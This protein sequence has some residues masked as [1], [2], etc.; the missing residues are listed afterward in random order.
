MRF[1]QTLTFQNE[2]KSVSL[3]SVLLRGADEVN[4]S[5]SG[6]VDFQR[7]FEAKE[8]P[9]SFH[10][11]ESSAYLVIALIDYLE[12]VVSSPNSYFSKKTLANVRVS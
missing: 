12:Y 1:A 10:E 5:L 9:T 7:F 11:E 4:W 3:F 6:S 8:Y 2:V